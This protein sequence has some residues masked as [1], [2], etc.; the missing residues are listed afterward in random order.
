LQSRATI[1]TPPFHDQPDTPV[2]A[3]LGI[4]RLVVKRTIRLPP[5]H[6]PPHIGAMNGL[7]VL[8]EHVASP[9]RQRS[10]TARPLT[11]AMQTPEGACP[12][13]QRTRPGVARTHSSRLAAP[14]PRRKRWQS[15]FGQAN[16][17]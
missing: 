17:L 6:F 10:G 15:V 13:W 16:A 11:P 2:Q 9:V 7:G 14:L 4:I 3:E 1:D 5:P 12:P 8:L